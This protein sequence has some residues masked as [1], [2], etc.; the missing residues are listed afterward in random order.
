[1][2]LRPAIWNAGTSLFG[3]LPRRWRLTLVRALADAAM[4]GPDAGAGLRELAEA[5]EAVMSRLDHCAVRY[6]GGIHPKHRLTKYHDFFVNRVQRG[7]RILDVGC[8][9]GSVAHSLVLGGALVT[10]VDISA[11]NVEKAKRRYPHPGLSFVCG[12]ARTELP[13]DGFETIVLSN[14]LEHID[15]RV[16]FLRS[17]IRDPCVR[18]VLI[19]VPMFNR[20]WVVPLRRELGLSYYSDPTHYVEYTEEGFREEIGDAG[21]RIGHLEIQWGELWAEAQVCGR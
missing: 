20:H 6:E 14:V 2:G 16:A 5:E 9:D 17:I 18:R 19:R 4:R 3:V 11:Q 13:V 7:E 1:M 8:G 15:Q 10:G 21:L 12:D